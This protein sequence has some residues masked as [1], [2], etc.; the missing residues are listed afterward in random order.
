MAAK[1]KI[2]VAITRHRRA[3]L[4]SIFAATFAQALY[5]ELNLPVWMI[6]LPGYFWLNLIASIHVYR[7]AM[8]A[9]RS[10]MAYLA[11]LMEYCEERDYPNDKC[12]GCGRWKGKG[13]LG[14]CAYNTDWT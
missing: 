4:V 10:P 14:H 5:S 11:L 1:N 2:E 3:L 9:L 6:W 7:K 13:H 8:R 12:R